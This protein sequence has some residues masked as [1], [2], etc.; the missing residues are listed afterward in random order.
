VQVQL[1]DAG[2]Q[3]AQRLAQRGFVHAPGAAQAEQVVVA[4]QTR[5]AQTAAASSAHRAPRRAPALDPLW[6]SVL[7]TSRASHS[8]SYGSRT[9]RRP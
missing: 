3:V 8:G 1:C 9:A 2:A 4:S 6:A 7:D 5:P